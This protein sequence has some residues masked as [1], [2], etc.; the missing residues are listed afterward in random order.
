MRVP[1][2]AVGHVTVVTQGSGFPH[3]LYSEKNYFQ[4][5]I[6]KFKLQ[7]IGFQGIKHSVV[8]LMYCSCKTVLHGHCES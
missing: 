6:I 8:R 4:N 1:S 3:A 7:E 2:A 5:Q